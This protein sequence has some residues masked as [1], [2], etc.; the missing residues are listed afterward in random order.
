MRFPFQDAVTDRRAL[1]RVDL[2]TVIEFG[3]PPRQRRAGYQPDQQLAPELEAALGAEAARLA[4]IDDP[5][6]AV[7][8][9]TEVFNALDDALKA[10][11]EPRLRAVVALYGQFG[12]Y[13]RI[14]EAT[15]LSKSRVAQLYQEAKRRGL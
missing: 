5:A 11:A 2:C 4:A 3:V 9:V 12:S 6:E 14:A 8:A 7:A 10:V 15:G 13:G 1:V